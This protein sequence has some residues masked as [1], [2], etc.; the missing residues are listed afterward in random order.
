MAINDSDS[1]S[2]QDSTMERQ[3]EGSAEDNEKSG[4]EA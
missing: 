1:R 4:A 3:W 2:R